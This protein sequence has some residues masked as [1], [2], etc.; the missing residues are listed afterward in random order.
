MQWKRLFYFLPAVLWAGIILWLSLL[1]GNDLP[2]WWLFEKIYIDKWVH[3]TLHVVLVLLI[4]GGAF[5]ITESTLSSGAQF[6]I[7][8]IS[9]FYGFLIELL[10]ETLTTTRHFEWGD[11]IVDIIGAI[12]GVILARYLMVKKKFFMRHT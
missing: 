12:L 11:I 9:A 4:F 7:I 10:Q 1:P 3:V 2:K 8:L 6:Y 5:R